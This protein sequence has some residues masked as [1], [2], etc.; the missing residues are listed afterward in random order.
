MASPGVANLPWAPERLVEGLAG[1]GGDCT[2]NSKLEIVSNGIEILNPFPASWINHETFCAASQAYAT[3]L[4][5]AFGWLIRLQVPMLRLSHGIIVTASHS[6][7]IQLKM[8]VSAKGSS[9]REMVAHIPFSS[10]MRVCSSTSKP[11]DIPGGRSSGGGVIV[12]IISSASVWP[13]FL[14]LLGILP[15]A[16]LCLARLEAAKMDK[17]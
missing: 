5:F 2:S 10:L 11:A 12:V 16:T 14:L 7:P 9:A 1:V 17:N 6:I 8:K 15:S 4:C 3:K 13:F